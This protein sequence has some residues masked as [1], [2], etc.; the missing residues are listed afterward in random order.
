MTNPNHAHIT[1]L[2]DRSGSMSVIR[3][4]AEGGV[5][6]F[7]DEQR[8]VSGTCSLL[9]IDFDAPHG[10]ETDWYRVVHDGDVAAAPAYTLNPRGMT[11]LYD[12]MARAIARTG[13][14]L[15]AMPEDERPGKVFFVVQTDG[16]ENSSRETTL[17]Q[18]V[19]Q[20]KRQEQDYAWTFIFLGMGP[21]SWAQAQA[22]VGTQMVNN[23]TRSAAT[24]VAA[25]QTYY[26]AAASIGDAR[27]GKAANFGGSVDAQG[28]Y[29]PDDEP[30]A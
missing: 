17:T 20:I 29:T 6:T 27:M 9:L 8:K 24:G 23:V 10:T 22:F 5:R 7:I 14:K 28:N 1:L 26:V 13:E 25:G 12:A 3:D 30:E 21:D 11:A 15:E 2:C 16:Q 4:D 19:E 18:L